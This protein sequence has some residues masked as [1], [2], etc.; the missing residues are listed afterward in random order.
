MDYQELI[1]IPTFGDRLSALRLWDKPHI[2][3][4][5]ISNGFYK[6]TVWLRTRKDIAIRDLGCDLG[7]WGM[8]IRDRVENGVVLPGIMIIHHI[9]PITEEDLDNWSDKLL[10]PNNLITTSLDTHNAIHYKPEPEPYVE[11]K[12]GDTKLW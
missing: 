6:S 9:D 10:D 3:P 12:P 8:E 2:S 1:K 5:A 11:R 7:V 4:R